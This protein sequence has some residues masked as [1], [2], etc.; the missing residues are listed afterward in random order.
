[1]HFSVA[2]INGG[3]LVFTPAANANGAHYA[4]FSFQ[5]QDDGGTANGGVDADL[6]THSLT[7]DVTQVNDPPVAGAPVTLGSIG[8][9]SAAHLIGQADLLANASDIDGPPLAAI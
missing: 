1:Q 7:F 6:S 8:V 4:A 3:H 5:V 2:D 9:N